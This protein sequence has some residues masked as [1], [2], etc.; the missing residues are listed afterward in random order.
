MAADGKLFELD[1]ARR[2]ARWVRDESRRAQRDLAYMSRGF[3]LPVLQL[4]DDKPKSNADGTCQWSA[5]THKP[6]PPTR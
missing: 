1:D 6:P 2:H 5:L 4:A 3:V